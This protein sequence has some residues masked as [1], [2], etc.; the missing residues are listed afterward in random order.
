MKTSAS[1]RTV[2]PTLALALAASAACAGVTSI[3]LSQYQLAGQF[4]LPSAASEAS[5]VTFNWDTGTL[6]VLGDEGDAVVEVSTTGVQLSVM[7][8]S[9]FDDTEGLTYTGGGQ[10]VITEERLQ[11]AYQFTYTGGGNAVRNTLPTASLGPTVGNI[12]IEGISYDPANGHFIAVKE[13]SPQQVLD[14]QIDFNASS[15]TVADLF[16]P[17]LG[18]L[19][20]SD[21]QVLGTVPSLVGTPDG[22]NLLVYSQESSLL[23]E[24]TRAGVILSTF[25]FAALAGDAEGVTIDSNGVIYVVG[26][27]PEMFVLVPVPAP[28][29]MALLAVAGLTGARRRRR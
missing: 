15:A 22:D 27:A 12:G 23:M 1:V 6:F 4:P 14:V 29:A 10:F 18:V 5:A 20:L 7:S 19:D 24:V 26:E 11:D 28:G 2:V 8:L 9:G 13:K 17:A 3:D 16:V 25:N 21:V